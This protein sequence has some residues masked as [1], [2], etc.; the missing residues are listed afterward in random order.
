MDKPDTPADKLERIADKPLRSPL[1]IVVI[2]TITP[3]HPKT[4]EVEQILSAG[5]ATQ[6]IMLAANAM[7]FG[8][9]WLTGPN[10]T[11]PHVRSALGVS[12]HDEIVGFVYLGSPSIKPPSPKRPV[13]SEHFT[14]WHGPQ[15]A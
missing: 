1:I 2:A 5:A 6:Q 14:T 3:D 10:A 7:G 11:H 9:I 15:S 12:G 13:L 8:S 4:P